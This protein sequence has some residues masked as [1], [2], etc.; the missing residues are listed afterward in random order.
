[1]RGSAAHFRRRRL[2]Y[3]TATPKTIS[4]PMMARKSR[5]AEP[6]ENV[7]V[8]NRGDRKLVENE[9]RGVIG[10]ALTFQNH[11]G[12]ARQSEPTSNRHR[13]NLIG[14]R[15]DGS[16]HKA[17]RPI[18][19]EKKV[20]NGADGRRCEGQAADGEQ[21]DGADVVAE[22][23]PAHRDSSRVD[24]GRYISRSTKSGASSTSGS[25]GVTA[26][27]RPTR[28]HDN[29]GRKLR[30]ACRDSGHRD[31]CENENEKKVRL[32]KPAPREHLGRHLSSNAQVE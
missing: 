13:S 3:P 23:A 6:N 10:E 8:A 12:A 7:P 22:L 29:S 30:P 1:M 25:P 28:T 24:Q 17:D 16:Q 15:Y 18:P 20:G 31:G 14:R 32:H 19:A 5:N 9:G 21:A 11:D 27:T 4:P 2:A 26:S